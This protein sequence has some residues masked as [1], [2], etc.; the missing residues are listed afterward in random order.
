MIIGTLEALA[1]ATAVSFYLRIPLGAGFL[2]YPS[3][4][5]L[6]LYIADFFGVL[7]PASQF[8]HFMTILLFLGWARKVWLAGDWQRVQQDLPRYFLIGSICAFAIVQAALL[9][10]T[11]EFYSWD[12]FSHWGTIIRLIYE[13]NTFHFTPNPLYFQD[14]PPGLALFS[15]HFLQVT[16]YSEGS[17]YFSYALLMFCFSAS[18]VQL[19]A[20]RTALGSVLAVV[21]IWLSAEVLGPGWASLLIDHMLAFF[22][23]GIVATYYL[24]RVAGGKVLIFPIF[25]AAFVLTKQAAFSFAM[26]VSAII[27]ADWMLSQFH[28]TIGER[29]GL[30]IKVWI[31]AAGLMAALSGA[32]L[33]TALSWKYYVAAA[34]LQVGWGTYSPASH[35]GH[36]L[37]CCESTREMAVSSKFFAAFFNA[38]ES[39]QTPGSIIEFAWQALKGGDWTRLLGDLFSP[40]LLTDTPGVAMAVLSVASLSLVLISRNRIDRL[41]NAT[42]AALMILGGIG[43]TI[44]LLMTYL[45]AF[46][47]YEAVTLA[48]FNRFFSV[49]VLAWLMCWFAASFVMFNQF[50]L[51]ATRTV[52]AF[53]CVLI[54]L[55]Y[56]SHIMKAKPILTPGGYNSAYETALR[57]YRIPARDSIR[58]WVAGF[59]RELPVDARVFV[60]WPQTSGLEFWLVKHELLPRMTNLTCFAI[61]RSMQPELVQECTMSEERAREALENYDYVA[62]GDHFQDLRQQYPRIFADTSAAAKRGLF[63]VVVEPELHLIPYDHQ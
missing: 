7:Q 6:C 61:T 43:Y 11:R 54:P 20:N 35:I 4:V 27:T 60:L 55:T 17:A 52:Y 16:D 18:L 34:G 37:D 38:A 50:P 48:S 57:N 23:G 53:L 36:F 22:F 25:L 33:L 26:L 56:G 5:I 63:R 30:G 8:I 47:E 62:V 29:R 58:K 21:M 15:Y 24:V 13:A 3:T 41:R 31:S 49:Y 40:R 1:F 39:Q 10:S 12:E 42:F 59:S 14:Y 28:R 44:T 51:R 46:S 32:A 2:L 19:A 45:Y 9:C